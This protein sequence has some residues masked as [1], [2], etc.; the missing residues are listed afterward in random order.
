MNEDIDEINEHQ[1]AA[2][3][4][5]SENN[6]ATSSENEFSVLYWQLNMEYRI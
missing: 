2:W 1:K 6:Q 5:W 4:I 3:K